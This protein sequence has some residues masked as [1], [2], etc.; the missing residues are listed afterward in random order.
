MLLKVVS[1][2][3]LLN[4]AVAQEPLRNFAPFGTTVGDETMSRP[5]DSLTS[6]VHI[7]IRF[8]FFNKSYDEIKLYSHGLILF[9]NVTYNLPHQPPG[10]FPLRD[11]AIITTNGLY[12]FTIFTY[13]QLPWSA[14]AWGGFPQVGFNAGDQVKFFTLV[15]S[16][17]SDVIDIV[18][19]SNIGVAGQ[20]IFHTTDPVNDVQ[21]NTTQGLQ[22]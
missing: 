5:I 21:C 4:G 19:E 1:F 22:A 16:F 18:S 12:L 9:G 8:S 2:V 3:L 17:T 10:L 11:F 6:S 7:N 13:N 15:K 20:F 14:G